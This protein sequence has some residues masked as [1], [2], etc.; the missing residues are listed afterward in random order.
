LVAKDEWLFVGHT[1]RPFIRKVGRLTLVNP[2][3]LG[4]PVDGD[5]RAC[6]AIWQDGDVTLRRI[7]YDVERAVKRLHD[8]GL[9]EEAADKMAS[10]LRLAGRNG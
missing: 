5:P 10:V 2:G 3:S 4:M 9:P 6:V 1:N 7:R 8:S